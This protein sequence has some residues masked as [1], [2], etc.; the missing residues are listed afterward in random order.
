MCAE[1]CMVIKENNIDELKQAVEENKVLR[2]QML[3]DAED[4]MTF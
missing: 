3:K 2:E 4:I 1:T